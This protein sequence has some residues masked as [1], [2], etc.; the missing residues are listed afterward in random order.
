MTGRIPRNT[1]RLDQLRQKQR[2]ERQEQ[3]GR[4]SQESQDR[5]SEITEG[6]DAGRFED[7]AYKKSPWKPGGE[8]FSESKKDIS[9]GRERGRERS[10]QRKRTRG[11]KPPDDT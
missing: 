7:R 9:E 4:H 6:K 8:E 3:A 2:I 10:R 11:P 5:A 1:H